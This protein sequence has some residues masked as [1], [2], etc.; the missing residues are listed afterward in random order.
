MVR[1]PSGPVPSAAIAWPITA[2]P[3][4]AMSTSVARP[5]PHIARSTAEVGGDAGVKNLRNRARA[6]S[7]VTNDLIASQSAAAA[8]PDL[9]GGGIQLSSGHRPSLPL[10][11]KSVNQT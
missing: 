3:T 2:P 9:D 5:A 4:V 1:P 10:I 11:A 8:A 7:P 6:D